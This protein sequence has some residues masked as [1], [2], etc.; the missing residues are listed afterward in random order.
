MAA[1]NAIAA[2]ARMTGMGIPG[3]TDG[4]AMPIP[5]PYAAAAQAIV[6][7]PARMRPAIDVAAID[8]AIRDTA[9]ARREL[10]HDS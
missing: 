4:G 8:A 6:V 1:M 10:A 9:K 2:I 3:R 5:A 7:A